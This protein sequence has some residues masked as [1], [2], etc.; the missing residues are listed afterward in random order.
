MG[1]PG[2]GAPLLASWDPGTGAYTEAAIGRTDAAAAK[3]AVGR[4]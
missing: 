3:F 4:R 1:V 2:K